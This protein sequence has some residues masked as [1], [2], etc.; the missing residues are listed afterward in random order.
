MGG[1]ARHVI[2]AVN[3]ALQ[4]IADTNEWYIIHLKEAQ[5]AMIAESL[6]N[7][8]LGGYVFRCANLHTEK[9]SRE[10][11]A[12]KLKVSPR[13]VS[14]ARK[15][16]QNATPEVRKAVEARSLDVFQFVPKALAACRCRAN[17][18]LGFPGGLCC[19]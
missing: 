14:T 8:P 2:Q 7:M 12:K 9:S 18:A 13:S 17:G 15:I 19:F 3:R 11:A 4:R 6:A 5:R 10:D 16:K 1:E